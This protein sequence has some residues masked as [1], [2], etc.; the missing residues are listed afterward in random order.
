MA[1]SAGSFSPSSAPR[2]GRSIPLAATA[3]VLI[4]AGGLAACGGEEDHS[5]T[6]DAVRQALDRAGT[7]PVE[8]VDSSGDSLYIHTGWPPRPMGSLVD[9]VCDIVRD[10]GW[11]DDGY[12][13]VLDQNSDVLTTCGTSP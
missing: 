1:D 13:E 8:L 5:D 2:A 6:A 12:I 9:N 4:F 7:V 11:P 3:V 10:A